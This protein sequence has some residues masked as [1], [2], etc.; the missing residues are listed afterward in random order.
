MPL[1]VLVQRERNCCGGPGYSITV[2]VRAKDCAAVSYY[3]AFSKDIEPMPIDQRSTL[4][5]RKVGELVASIQSACGLADV[6]PITTAEVS[7]LANDPN[8]TPQNH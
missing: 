2:T 8:A 6:H 4:V 1:F 7:G 3:L 5:G